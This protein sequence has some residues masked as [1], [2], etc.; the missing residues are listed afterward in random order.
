MSNKNPPKNA[1]T[2]NNQP[3]PGNTRGKSSKT[4][5]ANALQ[6]A[7][8]WTEDDYWDWIVVEAIDNKNKDAADVLNS[9]MAPKART[10]LPNVQFTL[11]RKAPFDQQI[12]DVIELVSKSDLSPDEGTEIVNLIKSRAAVFEST[13]L[14]ARIEQLEAY[15]EARKAKPTDE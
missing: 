13:V 7:K 1:W 4:K 10:K 9:A 15:A 5:A 14:V 3:T 2:S 8:G 12:G 11:D 6:R